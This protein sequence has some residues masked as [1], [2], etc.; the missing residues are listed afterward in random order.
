MG[1]QVFTYSAPDIRN[2]VDELNKKGAPLIKSY[3]NRLW[4]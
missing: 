3:K 2:I 4:D 1:M